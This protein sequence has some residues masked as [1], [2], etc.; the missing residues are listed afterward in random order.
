MNVS[1][2]VDV[3]MQDSE[4]SIAPFDMDKFLLDRE[5]DPWQDIFVTLED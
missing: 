5:H 1:E 4:G 3:W 2:I